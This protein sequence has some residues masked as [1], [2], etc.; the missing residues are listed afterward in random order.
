[1]SEQERPYNPDFGDD[2]RD[3][4][5]RDSDS[6]TLVVYRI[7]RLEKIVEKLVENQNM[8]V[9]SELSILENA[10]AITAMNDRLTYQGKAMDEFAKDM[11]N[12]KVTVKAHSWLIGVVSVAFVVML[13]NKFGALL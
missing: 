9:R 10:R 13:V 1:M 2:R 3:I 8:L 5:R 7:D 12:T 11:E 6:N 4:I